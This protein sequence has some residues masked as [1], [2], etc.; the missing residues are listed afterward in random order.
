MGRDKKKEKIINIVAILSITL[1][2][3]LVI[4]LTYFAIQSSKKEE[5]TTLEYE[6]Q[7]FDK[8]QVMSVNIIMDEDKW[9]DMLENATKEEYYS[10]DIEINGTTYKNV[11][12]RPKGNTSLSQVASDD[13]TDRFSFKIEFDH[14]VDGTRYIIMEFKLT[15]RSPVI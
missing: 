11:G 6:T 1:A 4:F 7:L 2:L 15:G 13:T 14:Y 8:D 12:I 3:F 5:K 10:C 9:K